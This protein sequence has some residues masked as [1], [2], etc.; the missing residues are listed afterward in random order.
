MTLLPLEMRKIAL[1]V[2]DDP[3]QRALVTLLLEESD[4]RV[5]GCASADAALAVMQYTGLEV[6]LVFADIRLPGLRD[7]VDLA[8]H[9]AAHWPNTK[10]V[11]TSGGPLRDDLPGGATFLAKP[12]RALDVLAQVA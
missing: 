11:V 5:V 3:D 8:R 4:L 9:V 6:A 1:V 10:I 12:W 2:E 7:G